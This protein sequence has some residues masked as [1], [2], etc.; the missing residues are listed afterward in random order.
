[1]RGVYSDLLFKFHACAAARLPAAWRAPASL[2]EVAEGAALPPAAFRARFS[3][4]NAPVILRGAVAGWRALRTWTPA[5][6]AAAGGRGRFHCGGVPLPLADFFRYSGAASGRDDRPLY[7]FERDFFA[8]APSLAE[9]VAPPPPGVGEDL[10]ALLPPRARPDARWVIAGGRKSGSTFHKDPNASSAWNALVYGE[11]AW[12]L[13]P[14]HAT[15][16][17]VL[18][19][20][21]GTEVATPLSVMEWYLDHFPAHAARAR[22]G[23]PDAPLCGLQR[24]GDVV[25]IPAGWWHQVLNLEDSLAVTHN[26]VAPDNLPGALALMREDPGALSGVPPGARPEELY[27]LLRAALAEQRRGALEAAEGRAAGGGGGDGGGGGAAQAPLPPP[28]TR[29]KAAP[30]WAEVVRAAA[31]AAAPAAQQKGGAA[32]EAH[33]FSFCFAAQGE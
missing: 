8:L 3:A 18:V 32:K 9:D 7:L 33:S 6:L 14:P 24:P 27:G 4:P 26:F 23:G 5:A 17:G 22:A 15:P 10:L 21:D 1:M 29:Q 20:G 19:S 16:P 11:K 28:P 25:F 30:K 31:A 12:V 2:P 13:Y